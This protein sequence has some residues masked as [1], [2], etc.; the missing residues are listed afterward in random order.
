MN[1]SSCLRHLCLLG[2][3]LSGATCFSAQPAAVVAL[4]NRI[5]HL[6]SSV[7]KVPFLLG[8]GVA[9]ATGLAVTW[10]L[11]VCW[12]SYILNLGKEIMHQN[13]IQAVALEINLSPAGQAPSMNRAAESCCSRLFKD[14]KVCKA[15]L[16]CL[17]RLGAIAASAYVVG[18][19]T[20]QLVNAKQVATQAVASVQRCVNNYAI[21]VTVHNVTQK[22]IQQ[23]NGVVVVGALVDHGMPEK[24]DAL[25]HQY[26]VAIDSA[27]VQLDACSYSLFS[28]EASRALMA[29]KNDMRTINGSYHLGNQ[30]LFDAAYE[31]KD[32]LGL[33]ARLYM[34]G[35]QQK[36][37]PDDND[38]MLDMVQQCNQSLMIIFRELESE[39]QGV[40]PDL[41]RAVYWTA[42]VSPVM[43]A[44]GLVK[45]S[46]MVAKGYLSDLLHREADE[47]KTI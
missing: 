5:V 26:Q 27:L 18:K 29:L 46:A 17:L 10:P 24:F 12:P 13:D 14:L 31:H 9:V 7:S 33:I 43:D 41:D 47:N 23:I 6:E 36:Q 1:K 15:G 39:L 32:A 30:D 45:V 22:A 19:L 28:D 4:E 3:S 2:L 44:C 35:D 38:G 16:P 37:N 11:N 20:H 8:G 40:Q 34:L 21:L 42:K 25:I